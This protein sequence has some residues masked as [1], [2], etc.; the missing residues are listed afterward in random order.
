MTWPP[1]LLWHVHVLSNL[2]GTAAFAGCSELHD[3]WLLKA[4]V[5]YVLL[6]HAVCTSPSP[7]NLLHSAPLFFSS[8]RGRG[9]CQCAYALIEGL[10]GHRTALLYFFGPG[11]VVWIALW[12][13]WKPVLCPRWFTLTS[14]ML[15]KRALVMSGLLTGRFACVSDLWPSGP[16]YLILSLLT[17][18]SACLV[19]LSLGMIVEVSRRVF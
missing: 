7:G 14:S 10:E 8:W 18:A 17:L 3:H 4:G 12:R 1:G 5:C 19:H 9:S 16:G 13:P 15:V 11:W 6:V 2:E